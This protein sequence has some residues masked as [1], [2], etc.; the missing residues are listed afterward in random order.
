VPE[1]F[2]LAAVD[3]PPLRPLALLRELGA[4]CASGG[5][6]RRQNSRGGA[7][8]ARMARTRSATRSKA[9]AA[10]NWTARC[11]SLGKKTF[12]AARLVLT[13]WDFFNSEGSGRVNDP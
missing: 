13:G 2:S 1:C 7:V 6:A 5:E 10:P 9:F 12:R 11:C 3:V 8:R 4:F